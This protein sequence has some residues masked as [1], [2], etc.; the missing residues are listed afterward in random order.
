MKTFRFQ[1]FDIL[2]N[3]DVFR[4]GTDAVLLGTLANVSEAKNI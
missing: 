2:Q 1:Q 3:S 4:V